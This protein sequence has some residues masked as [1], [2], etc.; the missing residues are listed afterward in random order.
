MK[1][2]VSQNRLKSSRKILQEVILIKLHIREESAKVKK[3]NREV[4]NN[5]LKTVNLWI[6]LLMDES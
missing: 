4:T 3:M 6:S 2:M 1:K 5:F